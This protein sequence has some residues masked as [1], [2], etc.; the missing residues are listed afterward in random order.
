[1]GIAVVPLDFLPIHA[2]SLP[3]TAAI[4]REH[5]T[6]SI[7]SMGGR[8]QTHNEQTR[9]PIPKIGHRLAPVIP[10][11]VGA[12]FLAGNVAT[13]VDQPRATLTSNDVLVQLARGRSV[14]E[15]PPPE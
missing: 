5:A 13:M 8:R 4:P 1:M 2:E 7:R 15:K 10:L 11:G 14:D 3:V 9:L 12:A 6:R